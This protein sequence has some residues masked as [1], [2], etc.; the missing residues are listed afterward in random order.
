MSDE[1]AIGE[2]FFRR[3]KN[4]AYFRRNLL[5]ASKSTLSILKQVYS[6]K[7]IR[8]AKHQLINLINR[9]IKEIRMLVQKINEV[10]PQYDKEELEKKF[11][12]LMMQRA[13]QIAEMPEERFEEK[14]HEPTHHVE[15]PTSDIEKLTRALDEVQNKLKNL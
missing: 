5:E 4:P 1:Q 11:P 15:E 2:E 7:Q 6:I 12:D 3:I 9:E 13:I 8:E 10:I 14:E